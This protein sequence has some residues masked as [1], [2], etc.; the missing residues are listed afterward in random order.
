MIDADEYAARNQLFYDQYKAGTLDIHEYLAFALRPLSEIDPVELTRIHAR[1]MNERIR[2]AI[3][4]KARALVNEHLE[5]GALCALVTATNSF[6]TAPI[7]A[8]FRIPNL[9][10]TEPEIVH[11]RFTG[12]CLGVPCF[13][14]GK[15][16]RV[17]LWLASLG[18]TFEDFDESR[19]YSDSH[20]DLPLMA[21]V[22]SPVAVDPDGRLLL[23]ARRRGWDV[24]SLRDGST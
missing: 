5:S 12:R 8:E 13:R 11:G 22:K 9:I 1:F 16:Q 21:R 3:S 4:G 17:T 7:A 20:N 18:R 6:V 23:E 15:V 2:S 14:E 10:A 19:F 24:I